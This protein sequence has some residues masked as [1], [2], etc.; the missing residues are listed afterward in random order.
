MYEVAEFYTVQQYLLCH[1]RLSVTV[2][3]MCCN[4]WQFNLALQDAKILFCISSAR[5]M[6]SLR[7]QHWNCG[8][9]GQRFSSGLCISTPSNSLAV[10]Q[11]YILLRV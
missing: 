6:W 9:S 11:E 4:F 8:A 2:L 10:V 3:S 7:K 5:Q 1:H